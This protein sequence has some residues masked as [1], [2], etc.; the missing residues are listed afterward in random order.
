M[1]AGLPIINTLNDLVNS[2][3]KVIRIE[4]VMSGTLNYI[5][6]TLSEEVPLSQAIRMARE[7]ASRNPI[8]GSI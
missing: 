4:A 6:N 2:G 7:A 1:G 8:R 5:F 3:D